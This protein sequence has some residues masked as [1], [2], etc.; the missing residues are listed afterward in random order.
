MQ[1]A[2]SHSLRSHVCGLSS[3]FSEAHVPGKNRLYL[4][5]SSADDGTLRGSCTK[6][7]VYALFRQ[8]ERDRSRDLSRFFDFFCDAKKFSTNGAKMYREVTPPEKNGPFSKIMPKKG[9][10]NQLQNY[11]RTNVLL[12]NG[13][14]FP[15]YLGYSEK[16]EG[17]NP[18]NFGA[19]PLYWNYWWSE[20]E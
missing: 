13:R 20:M 8:P 4:I 19:E 10:E 17:I 6:S 14:F 11:N 3:V 9:R 1:A 16:K 12:K 7:D 2:A 18:C 5:P 15:K